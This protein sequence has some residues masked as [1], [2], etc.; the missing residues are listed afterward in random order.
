VGQLRGS[1]RKNYFQWLEKMLYLRWF[2]LAKKEGEKNREELL[3][4]G[5]IADFCYLVPQ[6]CPMR[7]IWSHLNFSQD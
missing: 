1:F 6:E 7:R 3:L 4:R 2:W 5:F